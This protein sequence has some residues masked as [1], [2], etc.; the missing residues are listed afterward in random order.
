MWCGCTV[1]AASCVACTPEASFVARACWNG[2]CCSALAVSVAQMCCSGWPVQHHVLLKLSGPGWSG[3]MLR[4]TCQGPT[5]SSL[6]SA[7]ASL[8]RSTPPQLSCILPPASGVVCSGR[9]HAS[10]AQQEASLCCLPRA[11]PALLQDHPL[12]IGKEQTIS[13]PHMHAAAL[14]LLEQQAGPGASV[15]D[16]GSGKP[17][18]LPIPPSSPPQAALLYWRT[19]APIRWLHVLP[20]PAASCMTSLQMPWNGGARLDWLQHR[21]ASF[22]RQRNPATTVHQACQLWQASAQPGHPCAGSGYLT[23]A[24]GLLVGDSG[25]VLG[26]EQHAEL[27]ERSRGSLQR[28]IPDLMKVSGPQCLPMTQ[29]RQTSASGACLVWLPRQLPSGCIAAA[30]EGITGA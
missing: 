11:D 30:C 4:C 29:L 14:Q 28:A 10:H 9:A 26:V 16:V 21:P 25:R 27:A 20:L 15:L 7:A 13:A 17:Q 5:E 22:A 18:T 8:L 12:P 24:F 23:G 2:L 19:T 6:Q 1:L 3:V